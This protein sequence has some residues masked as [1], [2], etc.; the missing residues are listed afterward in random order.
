MAKPWLLSVAAWISEEGQ[1]PS[2]GSVKMSVR[3]PWKSSM[4]VVI[5][6]RKSETVLQKQRV[7]V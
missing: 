5:W 4:L 7:L 2:C 3:A 1:A 6:V